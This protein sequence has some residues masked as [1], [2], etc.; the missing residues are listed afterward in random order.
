MS[1]RI[2]ALAVAAAL[3]A[4]WWCLGVGP[5]VAH[6]ELQARSPEQG[7]VLDTAPKTIRLT[8]TEELGGGSLAVATSGRSV[9]AG[10]ARVDGAEIVLDVAAGSPA[11]VWTVAYR[12]VSADGH[13]VTGQYQFTVKADPATST[14]AP[15]DTPSS[16]PSPT[17]GTTPTPTAASAPTGMAHESPAVEI[18]V[19][20]IALAALVV[21]V[22]YRRRRP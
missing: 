2:R 11:G 4:C 14:P 9:G 5:A 12:V 6:T 13:P 22:F 15:F 7:V 3:T 18:A 19:T 20:V 16:A 21:G 10:P 8:F 17:A 1:S